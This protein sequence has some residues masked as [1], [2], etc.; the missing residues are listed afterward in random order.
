MQRVLCFK[1]SSWLSSALRSKQ[2][3]V[4]LQILSGIGSPFYSDQEEKVEKVS[5][6]A[7]KEEIQEVDLQDISLPLCHEQNWQAHSCPLV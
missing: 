5:Y 1:P 6:V 7:Y 2:T 4:S 3:T